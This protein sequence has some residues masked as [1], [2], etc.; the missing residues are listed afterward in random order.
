MANQLKKIIY[1]I[2]AMTSDIKYYTMIDH[3][4]GEL[5]M[6]KVGTH[7]LTGFVVV[8]MHWVAIGLIL[9]IYRL[10]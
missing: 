3:I 7:L 4:N 5:G 6:G 10:G 2:P 9:I 1:T 8:A